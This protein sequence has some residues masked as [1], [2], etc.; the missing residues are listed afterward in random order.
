MIVSPKG[1]VP[2]Q[3]EGKLIREKEKRAE[4]I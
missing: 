2:I 4:L 1:R 3:R